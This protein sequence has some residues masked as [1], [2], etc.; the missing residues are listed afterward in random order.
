[1]QKKVDKQKIQISDLKQQTSYEKRLDSN[2]IE[3]LENKVSEVL[4]D[5]GIL[6]Q[7]TIQLE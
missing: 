5:N 3:V 7:Q 6:K 4:A 1:M 2:T